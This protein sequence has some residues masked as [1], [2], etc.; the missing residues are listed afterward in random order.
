MTT[1][2]LTKTE[3]QQGV[4]RGIVTRKGDNTEMPL[5]VVTHQGDPIEHVTV[6]HDEKAGHWQIAIPIPPEAIADGIQTL[7][8]TDQSS[9]E[10]LGH[11]T[12]L[13]GEALGDDIRA[14]MDLLR[15]ELDML[16]RAFRRHCLET[17]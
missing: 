3:M 1:L 8:I 17:D 4:W 12:I 10:K 13:A 14:E 15:A 9:G 11:V 5:I 6:T 2:E 16:K 7:I